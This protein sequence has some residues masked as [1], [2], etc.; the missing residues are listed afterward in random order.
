MLIIVSFGRVAER[1]VIADLRQGQAHVDAV[2]VAGTMS[3][4]VVPNGLGG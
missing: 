3:I 1:D 4:N 2:A